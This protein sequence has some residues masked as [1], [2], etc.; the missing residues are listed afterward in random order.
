MYTNYLL[1]FHP[2][3]VATIRMYL[4]LVGCQTVQDILN[5]DH[6]KQDMK[7]KVHLVFLFFHTHRSYSLIS[8]DGSLDPVRQF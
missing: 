1:N 8:K 2:H 4:Y 5:V 7:N 3:Y 6:D